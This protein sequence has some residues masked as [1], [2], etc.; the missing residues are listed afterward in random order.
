MVANFTQAAKTLARDD[1]ANQVI[2]DEM[3][4]ENDLIYE[5]VGD[6]RD[7]TRAMM[8]NI[9][10]MFEQRRK[11]AGDGAS[12]HRSTS[13]KAAETQTDADR[14]A[15]SSGRESRTRTDIDRERI[16]PADRESALTQQFVE[17]GQADQEAQ[18]LAKNLGTEGPFVPI[19]LGST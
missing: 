7:Q 14:D 4:F 12:P 9:K 2:L 5:I 11:S 15:I 19:Q 3:G 17:F 16:P 13:N 10:Q 18:E 1:R 8:E 6:I